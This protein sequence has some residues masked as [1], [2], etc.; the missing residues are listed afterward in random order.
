MDALAAPM[1]RPVAMFFLSAVYSSMFKQLTAMGESPDDAGSE[2]SVLCSEA[3][4]LHRDAMAAGWSRSHDSDLD[5][6]AGIWT[7]MW[8][9]MERDAAG[10][11]VV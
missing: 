2:L 10:E 7:S 1:Q 3:A 5:V 11:W 8:E 6:A 4:L 9:A